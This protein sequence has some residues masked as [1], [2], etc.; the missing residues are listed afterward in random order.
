MCSKSSAQSCIS[1]ALGDIH[2]QKAKK[3]PTK[4]IH[5]KT[6]QRALALFWWSPVSCIIST[7]QKQPSPAELLLERSASPELGCPQGAPTRSTPAL[8]DTLPSHVPRCCY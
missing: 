5:T 8:W 6:Q 4:P 2:T 7:S 1:Q 3:K